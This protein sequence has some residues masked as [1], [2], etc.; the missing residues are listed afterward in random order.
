MTQISRPFQI[1][2]LAMVVLAGVWFFALQGHSSSGGTSTPASTPAAASSPPAGAA[3][4]KGAGSPTPIYNGA[5]PGVK[6]LSRA[7]ANA[8]KAVATSEHNAQHLAEKSAAASNT[9]STPAT[10]PV[11][12]TAPT[13]VHKVTVHTVNKH[14]APTHKV[15]VV[16]VAAP[17]AGAKSTVK[18]LPKM[19]VAVESE[20]KKGKLVAILFWNPKATV[21]VSVQ[22][23]LQAVG[24]SLGGKIVI[25]DANANQ[26]GEFGTITRAVQVYQ[27]PTILLVN[28]TGQTTIV[29]G[30][31]DAF[32]LKQAITEVEHP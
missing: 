10:T 29:T 5:A 3:Q 28:K 26:V 11:A 6:G 22:K 32:G 17:A 16:K 19:Q 20:L 30:L 13:T 31:T 14:V 2:L 7:I 12:P 21:D 24:R 25:H 9:A 23:E 4:A 1:A 27:T 18:G 15:T 8:H